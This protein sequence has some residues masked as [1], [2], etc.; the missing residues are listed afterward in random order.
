MAGSTT[1]LMDPTINGY[2]TEILSKTNQIHDKLVSL[3]G[4]FA[5]QTGLDACASVL[6]RM[7]KATVTYTSLGGDD[8]ELTVTGGLI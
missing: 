5:E 3:G 2:L 8:Y 4:N 6:D 7:Q 1:P